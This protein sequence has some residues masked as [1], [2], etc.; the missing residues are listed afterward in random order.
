ML[1]G[2]QLPKGSMRVSVLSSQRVAKN[3]STVSVR[4]SL[5]LMKDAIQSLSRQAEVKRFHGSR[6][7]GN[8]GSPRSVEQLTDRSCRFRPRM[9]V[10]PI[11]IVRC[12]L[13]EVLNHHFR[14]TDTY[15]GLAL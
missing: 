14:R 7:P 10:H 2:G 5:G 8:K 1:G 9:V 11:L 6:L 4:A 15:S 13:S 12:E 3:N